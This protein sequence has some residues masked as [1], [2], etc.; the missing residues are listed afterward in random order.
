MQD[1]RPG[2]SWMAPRRAS[3]GHAFRGIVSLIAT[4]PNARIHLA[5]ACVIAAGLFFQVS[6]QDWR[7]LILLIGWVWCMGALNTAIEHLC[8]TVTHDHN[9]GIRAAKDIAAAAVLISAIAA[10]I[11][12]LMIFLPY[13]L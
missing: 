5:A 9:P 3:F 4:E 13:L 1:K 8:D 11:I 10:S 6:G 7:W 2:K 12:G